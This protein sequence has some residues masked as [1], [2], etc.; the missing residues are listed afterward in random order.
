MGIVDS[1][2]LESRVDYAIRII[3]EDGIRHLGNLFEALWTEATPM[4][5]AMRKLEAPKGAAFNSPA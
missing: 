3:S 2:D 1:P 5:D 4:E